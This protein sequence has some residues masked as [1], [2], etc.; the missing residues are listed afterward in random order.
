MLQFRLRSVPPFSGNEYKKQHV[1]SKQRRGTNSQKNRNFQQHCCENLTTSQDRNQLKYSGTCAETRFRLSAKRTSPFK[2]AGASVQ[3][4]TGSRGV[5]RHRQQCW[6][7]H[8]P[9]QCEGY[10]LPT[11]FA[12]FPF[13]SP[14]YVTVCHHISTVVYHLPWAAKYLCQWSD[15]NV[16]PEHRSLIRLEIMFTLFVGRQ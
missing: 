5:R 15:L 1:H 2:S 3:S 10:W 9:R 6:I 12:S 7:H 16:M 14:P 8:V 4:T 13:T 11:Q